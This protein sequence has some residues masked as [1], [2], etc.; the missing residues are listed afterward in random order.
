MWCGLPFLEVRN[1][2]P[3]DLGF[4]SGFL[5]IFGCLAFR[6]EIKEGVPDPRGRLT[7]L[8]QGNRACPATPHEQG[9]GCLSVVFHEGL[10]GEFLGQICGPH[11][12]P[13]GHAAG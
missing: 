8:G 11:G 9:R 2:P 4:K 13:R 5:D 10:K 12:F 3:A 1:G 6:G 7:S